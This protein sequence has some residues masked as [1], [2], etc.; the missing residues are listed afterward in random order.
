MALEIDTIQ[1]LLGCQIQKAKHDE[2]MSR[3]EFSENIIVDNRR[4]RRRKL[5]WFGHVQRMED[6][7]LP[8][9]FMN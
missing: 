6:D 1:G 4:R 8:K 5:I 2:I 7:Y 9:I 3:M